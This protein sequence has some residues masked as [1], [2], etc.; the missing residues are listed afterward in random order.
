[1]APPTSEVGAVGRGD[2]EDVIVSEEVPSEEDIGDGE[3]GI[4]VEVPQGD[5]C[6]ASL[7]Q[8]ILGRSVI[9]GI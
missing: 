9:V 7:L 8:V 2:P 3:R 1:M 6:I 5:V 4:F